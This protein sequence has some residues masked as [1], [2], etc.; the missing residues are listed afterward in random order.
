MDL[1]KVS[2]LGEEVWAQFVGDV[3]TYPQLNLTEQDVDEETVE[4]AE[5]TQTPSETQGSAE[6]PRRL[7]QKSHEDQTSYLSEEAKD[8]SGMSASE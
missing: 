3:E 5:P 2:D 6:K 7:R 4:D 1:C 8:Q